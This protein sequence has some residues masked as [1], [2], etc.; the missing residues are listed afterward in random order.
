MKEEY[1]SMQLEY[2]RAETGLLGPYN[3]PKFDVES[4]VARLHIDRRALLR[5]GQEA[6]RSPSSSQTDSHCHVYI[7]L[8]QS[9][10]AYLFKRYCLSI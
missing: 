9:T 1:L 5:L 8:F 3:N 10:I 7:S 6:E 4:F 2:A